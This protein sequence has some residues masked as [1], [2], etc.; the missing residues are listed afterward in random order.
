L[1][2]MQEMRQYP[3]FVSEE[4]AHVLA[5][6]LFVGRYVYLDGLEK[7][8]YD[9][10]RE[11]TRTCHQHCLRRKIAAGPVCTNWP[12]GNRSEN[13]DAALSLLHLSV[14]TVGLVVSSHHKGH[15][16]QGRVINPASLSSKTAAV[17]DR[18]S[19]MEHRMLFMPTVGTRYCLRYLVPPVA[20][21]P[22]WRELSVVCGSTERPVT[23]Y[24]IHSLSLAH[25][26]S[27]RADLPPA[28]WARRLR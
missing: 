27:H 3:V 21:V 17:V 12:T 26:R 24:E 1:S 28:V 2:A 10:T 8:S 9:S 19:A 14:R 7:V 6:D 15:R 18:S 16:H 13:S 4:W 23:R 22:R 25:R 5:W 11:N 20:H